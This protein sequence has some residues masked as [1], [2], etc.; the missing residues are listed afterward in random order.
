[1]AKEMARLEGKA[2]LPEKTATPP[3]NTL[4]SFRARAEEPC[5]LVLVEESRPY[6]LVS[7]LS[8]TRHKPGSSH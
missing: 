7:C 2:I 6:L 3:E 5:L 4:L 8:H 1:M